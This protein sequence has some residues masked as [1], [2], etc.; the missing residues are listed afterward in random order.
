M[1]PINH[2]YAECVGDWEI[3]RK[4]GSADAAAPSFCIVWN[5]TKFAPKL[6]LGAAGA[7]WYYI[8][9]RHST[10]GDKQNQAV[11]KSAHE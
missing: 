6:V 4:T 8:R 2:F 10:R 11:S 1:E 3:Q 7:L 9:D 5:A